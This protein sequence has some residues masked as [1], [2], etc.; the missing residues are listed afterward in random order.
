M[1]LCETHRCSFWIGDLTVYE[2]DGPR[3]VSVHICPYC[4]EVL[5]D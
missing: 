3:A 2:D 5:E 1:T 4:D